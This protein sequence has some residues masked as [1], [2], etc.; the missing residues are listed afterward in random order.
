MGCDECIFPSYVASHSTFSTFFFFLKIT[1]GAS[2]YLLP[3][4][5]EQSK[6]KGNGKASRKGEFPNRGSYRDLTKADSR[7][8][9]RTSSVLCISNENS[10]LN[11]LTHESPRGQCNGV[12]LLTV[13]QFSFSRHPPFAIVSFLLPAEPFVQSTRLASAPV[14]ADFFICSAFLP[15]CQMMRSKFDFLTYVCVL[16]Y[17]HIYIL[18]LFY[19]PRMQ[20]QCYRH[21]TNLHPRSDPPIL[22]FVVLPI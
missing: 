6:K 19:T 20:T 16:T 11:F 18:P 1:G 4:K 2:P 9:I 17:H 21:G 15:I 13:W 22:V 12:S 10:D 7:N 5:S 14:I 3:R 8:Q